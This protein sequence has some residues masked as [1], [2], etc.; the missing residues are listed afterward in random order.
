MSFQHVCG[1][2]SYLQLF[3][4]W[5]FHHI[6]QR[7]EEHS[8]MQH[9]KQYWVYLSVRARSPPPNTHLTN[10][11]Y[12][13]ESFKGFD[14]EMW[15]SVYAL[16]KHAYSNILKILQPKTEN[17]QMKFCSCFFLFMFL[18]NIG[19]EYS[20]ESPHRGGSNEY[21][22]SMLLSRNKKNNVYPCKPQFY[23]IKWGLR[24]VKLYRY[25]FVMTIYHLYIVE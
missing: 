19:R 22:Q 5:Y 14:S 3:K 20:L 2:P 10:L 9:V 17:F 25:I 13:S 4:L 24:G 16:R 8:V 12:S 11:L 6:I 21:P 18:L 7:N 1:Y 23:Y 15:A